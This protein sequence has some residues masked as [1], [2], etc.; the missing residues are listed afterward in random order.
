MAAYQPEGG[1]IVVRSLAQDATEFQLSGV[2][3]A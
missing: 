3:M 2:E 1:N